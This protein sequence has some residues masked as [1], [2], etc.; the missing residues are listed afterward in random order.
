MASGD[1]RAAPAGL[2]SSSLLAFGVG[3]LPLGATCVDVESLPYFFMFLR[4]KLILDVLELEQHDL[5]CL[6]DY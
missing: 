1:R 4:G 3:R 5:E 6:K 2:L